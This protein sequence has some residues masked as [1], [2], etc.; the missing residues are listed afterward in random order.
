M[1]LLSLY[2][3]W[4]NIMLPNVPELCAVWC[5]GTPLSKI[6]KN[7]IPPREMS[8]KPVLVLRWPPG[9]LSVMVRQ[10]RS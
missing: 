5:C 10:Q 6:R 2:F 4:G 7:I 8:A 3:L 9:R 1:H